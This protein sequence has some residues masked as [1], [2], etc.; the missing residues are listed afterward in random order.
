MLPKTTAEIDA[1]DTRDFA[2]W[3][4]LLI[5][6]KGVTPQTPVAAFEAAG[7]IGLS[8]ENLIAFASRAP[9]AEQEA[10]RKN[11]VMLDVNNADV[12]DYLNHLLNVMIKVTG[13]DTYA[14]FVKTKYGVAF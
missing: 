14:G 13:M 5:S 1:I 8:Y 4:R 12:F 9:A 11:L 3:L 6:E 7:H 2:T 10:I